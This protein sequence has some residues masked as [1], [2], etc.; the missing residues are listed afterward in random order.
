MKRKTDLDVTIA[1]LDTVVSLMPY[2]TVETEGIPLGPGSAHDARI[3]WDIDHAGIQALVHLRKA[4]HV[5][6]PTTAQELHQDYVR[7]RTALNTFHEQIYGAVFQ[8]LEA[9][10]LELGNYDRVYQRPVIQ[11]D[12]ERNLIHDYGA[13]YRLHPS[14]QRLATYCAKQRVKPPRQPMDAVV[15]TYLK[16]RFALL[17]L[18]H[19]V[20]HGGMHVTDIVTNR[21][22][23]FIDKALSQTVNTG[24]FVICSLITLKDYTMTTGIGIP[25]D[26]HSQ[27]GRAT[28]SLFLKHRQTL[29]NYRR[30]TLPAYQ[31]AIQ[32]IYGFC[33]RN[34]ALTHH[35][36]NYAY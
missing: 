26:E 5:L 27:G 21:S 7:Q 13:L 31:Q 10:S 8:E 19:K 16:A 15:Q 25:I 24:R 2:D 32:S 4:H 34:G 30:P 17:R 1:W 6:S 12:S 20:A 9:I 14:G 28:L 29:K 3:M 36:T 33:L 23:V 22:F 18:D 35:T 11:N